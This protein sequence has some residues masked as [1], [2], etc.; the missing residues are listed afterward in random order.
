MK[1]Y[2]FG[3][4]MKS[5]SQSSRRPSQTD[6]IAK[7]YENLQEN[8]ERNL[9]LLQQMM[10]SQKIWKSDVKSAS[11]VVDYLNNNNNND[12]KVDCLEEK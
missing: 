4:Q 3:N 2:V 9:Q 10:K 5:S 1:S 7:Y 8:N 6:H 12:N 11:Q